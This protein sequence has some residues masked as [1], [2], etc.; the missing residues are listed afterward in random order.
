MIAGTEI[1]ARLSLMDLYGFLH[2]PFSKNEPSLTRQW[3]EKMYSIIKGNPMPEPIIKEGSLEELE[4]TYKSIGL[5]LLFLYR[6]GERTEAFYW[7]RL[8]EEIS[9]KVQERLKTDIKKF[10]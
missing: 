7:E 10:V 5:H 6:L 2:L 4:L 1:E 8:R 3:E 9:D